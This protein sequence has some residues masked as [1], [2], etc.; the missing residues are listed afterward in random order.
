MLQIQPTT[1]TR[2]GQVTIPA[3]V[4][5]ALGLRPGD[6][7]DFRITGKTKAEIKPKKKFS[8]MS[9]YGSLK[10]K[11]KPKL[12]GQ[13]LIKWEEQAWPKAAA[14]HDRKILRSAQK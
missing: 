10:P 4:R 5:K 13:E 8:I 9:L 3:P 14:E 12:T 1:V 11:V 6:Q 7:I 2:K